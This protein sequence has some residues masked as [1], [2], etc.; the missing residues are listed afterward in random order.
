[1]WSMWRRP[2][3]CYKIIIIMEWQEDEKMRKQKKPKLKWK[4][5]TIKIFS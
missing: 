5:A 1:M 3:N 2:N 4:C